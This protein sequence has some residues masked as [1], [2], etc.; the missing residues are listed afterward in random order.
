MTI[1]DDSCRIS[2]LA[3]MA[4]KGSLGNFSQDE[5]NNHSNLTQAIIALATKG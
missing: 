3:S 1:D 2:Q 4:K 5:I